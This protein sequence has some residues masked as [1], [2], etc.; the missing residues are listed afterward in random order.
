MNILVIDEGFI[1]SLL[2]ALG[3][4]RAGLE[5]VLFGAVG[6]RRRHSG[7]GLT[8]VT[9][10]RPDAADFLPTVRRLA[11]DHRCDVIYP[12]TEPVMLALHRAGADTAPVFPP[13]DSRQATLLGSKAALS[14]L[15]AS[16]GV[17]TPR[18]VSVGDALEVEAA[19]ARVGLPAVVK[20]TFGRGGDGTRIV[21]DAGA[22]RAA[23]AVLRQAGRNCIL[24]EYVSGPTFLVGG[25]FRDGVPLRLYAGE[26]VVQQPPRTGPAAVIRSTRAPGLIEAALPVFQA[27]RWTGLASADFVRSPGGEFCFLEVNPRPWGSIA[28]AADAGVD[29]FTP[30]ATLLADG[31]PAPDL[32]F[33]EGVETRVL[34]L[35]LMSLRHRLAWRALG[36]LTADL[37]SRQAEPFRDPGL[38]A[39]MTHRLLRVRANWPS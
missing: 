14:E 8:A 3:L 4:R 31:L 20:A 35:Y 26:K 24:Q 22:T 25:L 5:V 33:I 9:G 30:L 7:S 38:L 17:P 37:G 32:G 6:S 1:G 2:T 18:Q 27:L 23:L 12:A 10:P 28:A 36:R 19:L 34:P 16:L 21:A 15:V 13:L 11:E 39:H 29:L